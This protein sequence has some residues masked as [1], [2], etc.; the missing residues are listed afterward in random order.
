MTPFTPW[1]AI[2]ASERVTYAPAVLAWLD[3]I[4]VVDIEPERPRWTANRA[5]FLRRKLRR[6]GN[7]VY[8]LLNLPLPA[9]AWFGIGPD[10]PCWHSA[11]AQQRDEV[12]TRAYLRLLDEVTA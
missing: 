4:R 5:C 7:S 3:T 8:K 10:G 6:Q 12:I 11:L 2:A 1:S 9:A